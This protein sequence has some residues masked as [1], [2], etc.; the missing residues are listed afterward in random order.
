MIFKNLSVTAVSGREIWATWFKTRW[1]LEHG[2]VDLRPLITHELGLEDFEQAFSELEE[3][4]ACKIV[5]RPDTATRP[6]AVTP[7][8]ARAVEPGLAA[9][10]RWAHR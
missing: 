3:G 6:F 1:L 8:G 9:P 4:T 2:V 5:L 10:G 7:R